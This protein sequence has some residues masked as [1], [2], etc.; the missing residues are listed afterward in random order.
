M[1]ITPASQ[2]L[3]ERDRERDRD[4]AHPGG[5]EHGGLPP[6]TVELDD[7]QRDQHALQ[8]HERRPR[9]AGDRREQRIA[10]AV[11]EPVD[12]DGGDEQVE[13]VGDDGQEQDQAH[14][15]RPLAG[16]GTGVTRILM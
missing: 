7:E 15:L 13:A 14:E 9:L 6:I 3:A 1:T 12:A 16:V 10:L 2:P 4:E 5:G 8:Q 11:A